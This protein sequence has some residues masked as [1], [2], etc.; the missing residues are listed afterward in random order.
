MS[1]IK[2][3]ISKDKFNQIYYDKAFHNN[4]RYQIYFGGSSSGKSYAIVGQRT[5]YDIIQGKR[6]YLVIR[7]TANTITQ[8]VWLEV[9]STIYEWKLDKYFKINKSDRI[10]T[11]LLNKKQIIFRGLDD[12][13]K[14]KS[15]RALDG[16]ITDIL[17]EEATEVNGHNII[18]ELIKRQRGKSEVPKRITLLFNPVYKTHWIYKDFFAGLWED[19]KN[20]VE[21]DKLSIL[22]TTYKDNLHLTYEDTQDLE[23]ETDK[24]YYDVYT[25]G[26]WGVLGNRIFENWEV[27]DLTDIKETF[28]NYKNGADWGFGSDPFAFGRMHYDKKHKTIYFLDEIYKRGLLNDQSGKMVKKIIDNEIVTCD[29]S[30][31]K[32]IEEWRR[33]GLNARGAKKGKGSIEHGIKWL[34]QQR[35]IIDRKCQNAINEFT[36]Y[37]WK[38]DKNGEPIPTPT[39]K[40]NHLIDLIRYAFEDEMNDEKWFY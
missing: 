33:Y 37:K 30:E 9:I 24:Y 32:S 27:E 2:L 12:V 21:N 3:K 5:I 22:K 10:I 18:K 25:L 4:H 35:I 11:C 15:V 1:L 7:N 20:Y 28:D 26:N 31:P 38:E 39:D 13:Q 19:D 6:N 29:S 36:V 40:D 34:Q 14:I 16:A 8:S 23:N 17:I